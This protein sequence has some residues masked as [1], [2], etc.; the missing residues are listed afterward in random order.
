MRLAAYSLL[1][2][3]RCDLSGDSASITVEF[4]RRRRNSRAW[5]SQPASSGRAVARIRVKILG[6]YVGSVLADGGA[7]ASWS[8]TGPPRTA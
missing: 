3:D 5:A 2:A 1:E 4:R 7:F 8:R 6:P